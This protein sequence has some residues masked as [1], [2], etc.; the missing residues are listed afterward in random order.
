[1]E[2][3]NETGVMSNLPFEARQFISACRIASVYCVLACAINWTEGLQPSLMS[4]LVGLVL[5]LEG[6]R[7]KALRQ[8][9][10]DELQW[11]F[12]LFTSAGLALAW[13]L[14]GG[15]RGSI[16]MVFLLA[17]FLSLSTAEKHR[18]RFL[19]VYVISAFICLGIEFVEPDL[20]SLYPSPRSQF[21]D[22]GLGLLAALLALGYG[23]HHFKS[24]YDRQ[25]L[26]VQQKNEELVFSNR[27][28]QSVMKRNHEHLHCIA[29]DLR[30][31]VGAVIGLVEVCREEYELEEGLQRDLATMEVAAQ[32]ALGLISQLSEIAYLEERKVVLARS[33]VVLATLVERTVR[34]LEPS[35][36]KKQQVLQLHLDQALQAE[37]DPQRL[38]LVLDNLVENAIK[39]GPLEKPIQIHLEKAGSTAIFR[40]ADQGQGVPEEQKD[41][42]FTM[43][44]KVG[45][46]PTGKE[47][48]TGLGLYI[49]KM[50]TELHGGSLEQANLDPGCEFRLTLPL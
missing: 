9:L 14:H 13:F 26:R 2:R 32:Q 49:C 35:A 1:M 19:A 41:K 7:W 43:F 6:M 48:S 37:V 17:T 20:I 18:R 8:G 50:I 34:K 47:S 5:L 23:T 42:L 40:V 22:N 45:T 27:Q 39:Y 10:S 44:G 38:A 24:S 12:A 36:R 3:I 16:P 15:L 31:P 21:L 25:R 30:N 29:H 33:R 11:G 4:L 28:L 46:R